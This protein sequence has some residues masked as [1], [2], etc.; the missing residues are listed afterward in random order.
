MRWQVK[1]WGEDTG[2]S[3]ILKWMKKL[4]EN[5][6]DAILKQ[7]YFLKNLG[8]EL[9]LPHSKALGKGLFELREMEYGYRVYY[10]FHGKMIIIIVA[11]GDKTGQDRDIKI[12][13]ERLALVK[14]G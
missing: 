1:Y 7:L 14:K 4:T 11:S 3:P 2:V 5:Q 10:G 9:G 6:K 12:A 13:R 8:N